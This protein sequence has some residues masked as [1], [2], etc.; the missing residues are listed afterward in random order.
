MPRINSET[1]TLFLVSLLSFFLLKSFVDKSNTCLFLSGVTLGAIVLTKIMFGYVLMF[2]LLFGVLPWIWRRPREAHKR[3]IAVLLIAFAAAA[4]YLIYT[5]HLT[6]RMFYWGNS[7]GL[8]LYWLSTPY[9]G[10]FGDFRYGELPE[11][12]KRDLAPLSGLQGIARDDALKK[13][14]L[15]NIRSHPGKFAKNWAANL[16][17]LFFNF[18]YSPASNSLANVGDPLRA[19]AL[20]PLNAMVFL[21]MLYSFFITL[22]NWKQLEYFIRFLFSLVFLYL[23]ASSLVSAY[24]RQFY[25]IV[26]ALLLWMAYIADRSLK[27]K[28]KKVNGG[29]FSGI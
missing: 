21:L 8:S 14:A 25:V 15:N 28:I 17:R 6:G 16:G 27:V 23:G 3:G 13:I 4:P 5:Y 10:E 12:H 24:S 22:G 1:F 7:G 9:R 2:M 19:L 26:P 18:P 11:W 29:Q 20:L